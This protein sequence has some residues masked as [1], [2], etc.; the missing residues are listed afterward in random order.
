MFQYKH[1]I[2]KQRELLIWNKHIKHWV[3]VTRHTLHKLPPPPPFKVNNVIFNNNN[4]STEAQIADSCSVI[5]VMRDHLSAVDVCQM[6]LVW[7]HVYVRSSLWFIS[8]PA[9]IAT[10]WQKNIPS[11]TENESMKT[12]GYKRFPTHWTSHR[13][14]INP[15]LKN[16]S[17]AV[18]VWICLEPAI[19]IYWVRRVRKRLVR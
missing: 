18:L 11:I 6:I 1:M 9:T 4:N 10:W 16:G 14:Q 15:S 8:I 7:K 17:T 12:D 5:L 2:K 3:C 13:V 19:L